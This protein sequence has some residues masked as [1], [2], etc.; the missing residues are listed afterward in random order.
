MGSRPALGKQHLRRSPVFANCLHVLPPSHAPT[1]TANASATTPV[2]AV[3]GMKAGDAATWAKAVPAQ[4]HFHS[5]SEHTL[6][7]ELRAC[8]G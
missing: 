1:P 6:D 5:H 2:T 7:G 4:F 3:L 8:V